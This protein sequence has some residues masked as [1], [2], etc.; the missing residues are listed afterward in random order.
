MGCDD[1]V[2]DNEVLDGYYEEVPYE[3]KDT[4]YMGRYLVKSRRG[5]LLLPRHQH[6]IP[7]YSYTSYTRKVE[8]LRADF[9]A[10]GKCCWTAISP[11][12][13]LAKGEAIFL[14]RSYSKCTRAYG[15]IKDGFVYCAKELN[16]MLDLDLS[17]YPSQHIWMAMAMHIGV[18]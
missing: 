2:S 8:I 1:M 3:P 6:Q 4:I 14:G 10:S 11:S 18:L 7:P 12:D 17:H 5:E 16:D 9:S 15:D 13:G